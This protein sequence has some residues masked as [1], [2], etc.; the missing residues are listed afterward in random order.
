[1]VLFMGVCVHISCWRRSVTW[2]QAAGLGTKVRITP[3]GGGRFRDPYLIS[4][5][6]MNL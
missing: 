4:C 1:M 5:W 3:R 2:F 6:L